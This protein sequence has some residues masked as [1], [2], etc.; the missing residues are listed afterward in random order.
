[1]GP[2]LAGVYPA[3]SFS[4]DCLMCQALELVS[5]IEEINGTP[6]ECVVDTGA[7]VNVLPS[8]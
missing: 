5:H 7:E 8:G 2:P 1:M 6:L 3:V 4:K